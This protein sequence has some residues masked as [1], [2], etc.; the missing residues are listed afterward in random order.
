M[1]IKYN[2]LAMVMVFTLLN[3]AC[4]SLAQSTTKK[5][6]EVEFVT[7]ITAEMPEQD[8]YV[9][10]VAD[11]TEVYRIDGT[12][13]VEFMDA[14]VYAASETVEHDPFILGENPFGPYPKGTELGFT[15]EEWLAGRGK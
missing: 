7:H 8:V 10:K 9:A 13:A 1:S 11:A 5:Q 3:S 6:I 12:E 15:M 2:L 14:P 4:A